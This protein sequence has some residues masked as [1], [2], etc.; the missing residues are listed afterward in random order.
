MCRWD[1][2]DRSEGKPSELSFRFAR[3]RRSIGF[4]G[5]D[6]EPVFFRFTLFSD[7]PEVLGD[8][9]P[10]AASKRVCMRRPGM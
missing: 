7:S 4:P 2:S 6:R 3:L 9:I 10:A 8:V 5:A 1:C